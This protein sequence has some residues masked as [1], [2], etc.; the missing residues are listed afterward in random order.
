[1]HIYSYVC[2]VAIMLWNSDIIYSFVQIMR[3]DACML[4]GKV[5]NF[6]GHLKGV[7]MVVSLRL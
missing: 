3:M 7:C 1:M 6:N 2:T 5:N 4:Q